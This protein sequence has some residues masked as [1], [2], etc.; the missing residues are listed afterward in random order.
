M[1]HLNKLLIAFC[2]IAPVT[3]IQAQKTIPATGGNA[4]G[5]GGSASYSVGQVAYT[6]NI[7]ANA[8]VAQGVQ[9]PYEI[10]E[11][12]GIEEALGIILEC[13]IFPNPT[14]DILTL[15][16]ENYDIQNLSYKLFDATGKLLQSK[17]V[18]GNETKI[19]MVGLSPSVY[20]LKVVDNQKDLKTFKIIK[21]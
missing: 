1:K 12:V 20:F 3:S 16:V 18:T 11:I 13:S 10:S 19:S 21:Y 2:L 9:Q 17:E 4:S 7:G 8:S 15:K 5:A 6:T 14:N